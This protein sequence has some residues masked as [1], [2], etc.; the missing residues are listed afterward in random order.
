MFIKSIV[1]LLCIMVMHGNSETKERRVDPEVRRKI[2][3]LKARIK[4]DRVGEK[5]KSQR[6]SLKRVK[7]KEDKSPD[8]VTMGLQLGG[9]LF[10]ILILA[11]FSIRGLKKLQGSAA[12]WGK[13]TKKNSINIIETSFLGKNQR[14]V[15]VEVNNELL[16]L[17]VT[18][19]NI[20]L[21]SRMDKKEG[22]K[23]GASF[24]EA[25]SDEISTQ[26]EFGKSLNDYFMQ[27]KKKKPFARSKQNA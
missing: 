7:Q 1:I 25:Y 13:N 10:G 3:R 24:G 11:V 6:T 23:E 2:Q 16:L 18:S 19:E 14:V 22:E 27:F 15:M 4:A 5:R 20:Q 8:Y 9:G 17:G 26:A 12:L 21:I